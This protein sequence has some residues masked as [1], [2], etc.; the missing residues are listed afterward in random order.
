M[1][2]TTL[3]IWQITMPSYAQGSEPVVWKGRVYP[4]GTQI[5]PGIPANGVETSLITFPPPRGDDAQRY[6]HILHRASY[7]PTGG[8]I[9]RAGGSGYSFVPGAGFSFGHSRLSDY[10]GLLPAIEDFSGRLLGPSGLAQ[11]APEQPRKAPDPESGKDAKTDGVKCGNPVVVQTGNKIETEVDFGAAGEMGLVLAR[12]WNNSTGMV[13]M[14]GPKWVTVADQRLV[15]EGAAVQGEPG[16]VRIWRADGSN[17][18]FQRDTSTGRW[19]LPTGNKNSNFVERIPGT[20]T[21]RVVSSSGMVET[22]HQNGSLLSL[23]NPHSV[24]WAFDYADP[25]RIVDVRTPNPTLRSIIRTGGQQVI[26]FVWDTRFGKPVVRTVTAPDGGVYVYEY[27]PLTNRW[28]HLRTVTYPATPRSIGGAPVS[29]VVGYLADQELN[30]LGKEV[31]G[32]RYST[33][34]YDGLGRARTSEHAWGAERYTFNYAETASGTYTYVDNPLGKRTIYTYSLAGEEQRVDGLP[35]THC[36]TATNAVIERPAPNQERHIDADG[37]KVLLTFDEDRNVISMLQ[38][39]GTTSPFLTTYTWDQRPLRLRT[40]ITPAS[41]TVYTYHPGHGRLQSVSVRN[42]KPGIGDAVAKVTTYS[43]QFGHGNNFPSRIVVDGPLPGTGDAVWSDFNAAGLAVSS[44]SSV[45]T[46]SYSDHSG[47]GLARTVV[48]ANGLVQT[49][50]YDARSRMIATTVDGIGQWVAYDGHGQISE[51]QSQ[52]SPLTRFTYDSAGRF[53]RSHSVESYPNQI[54]RPDGSVYTAPLE[55]MVQVGRDAASNIVRTDVT[56]I[57]TWAVPCA[58]DFDAFNPYCVNGWQENRQSVPY[59]T[60]HT[61]FDEL[62]RIRAVRGNNGQNT[63]FVFNNGGQ[64]RQVFDSNGTEA[65]LTTFDEHLRPRTVRNA[66]G[67]SVV[68]DR[69]LFGLLS[70]VTDGKGNATTFK[71]DGLGQTWEQTSPDTGTT[72]SSFD[73]ATG[74]L[75]SILFADGRS[76]AYTYLADGR[77]SQIVAT[78]SGNALTR[79]LTYDI[80]THGRGR[81]CTVAETGGEAVSYAYNRNG[82]LA[83][84]TST[85]SGQPF[86]MGWSYH[87]ATGLPSRISYPNG[88]LVDLTWADGR[89]RDIDVRTSAAAAPVRVARQ[90]LYQPMGQVSSYSDPSGAMRVLYYDNDGR[91]NRILN[92]GGSRRLDYNN[93]NLITALTGDN[94]T[95]LGYDALHRVSSF[96]HDG[97]TVGLQFDAN[98]NRNQATYS[99]SPALPVTYVNSATSNRLT[100]VNWNGTSRMLSYDAV[101]NLRTDR[102]TASATD[103][104]YYDPLGRVVR[105]ARHAAGFNDC[106]SPS[107]AVTMNAVYAVNGLNQRTTKTVG[108]DVTRFVYGPSGELLYERRG[109]GG[110]FNEKAYIWFNGAVIAV[111]TNGSVHSVDS[112]HLGRPERVYSAQGALVWHAAN[113]P[114]SRNLKLDS[115]QGMN[116]G[117]P[118]QYFDGESGLWYNWH[119]YYEPALGRYTQ[120]DPIGLAGG[121]NTYSYAGGNPIQVIDPNGLSAVLL[122]GGCVASGAA[123]FVSADGFVAA[124]QD[125]QKAQDKRKACEAKDSRL[126]DAD[127]QRRDF[128]GKVA[129]FFGS[130]GSQIGAAI[131]KPMLIGVGAVAI[132]PA[133]GACAAA[134]FALGIWKG[135]GSTTRAIEAWIGIAAEKIGN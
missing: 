9:L 95:S 7:L 86:T 12:T 39:E 26:Q 112:D 29:T 38:G 93:L 24:G 60:M 87:V 59:V 31:D 37:Y 72:Q 81:L 134:G 15:M 25:A 48:D 114:F 97:L 85:A 127:P 63:R 36:P 69:D 109:V 45:G 94:G 119:R 122:A 117:F 54:W 96:T 108:S 133:K 11:G 47:S 111:V 100:H 51:A 106:A 1:L 102:R 83:T 57:E 22:Y 14:F 19:Q 18:V 101:G 67:Q 8:S 103:C 76:E 33:F 65:S 131:I 135:D 128:A 61:D 88:V 107:G 13:G 3:T 10:L 104:H 78:R 115:I 84:Q 113:A 130:F 21:L 126:G 27:A 121:M 110:G 23:F 132:D 5:G 62:N 90:I 79:T 28:G 56:R 17:L 129:D 58:D 6:E 41:E 124:A 123:G 92:R 71:T 2:A 91:L 64:T 105:I 118:G 73:P 98:G 46:T 68:F 43:Y 4:P 99:T 80:C 49:F 40:V 52:G 35:A 30:Y 34:T 116:V 42:L 89:L 125:F 55:N 75:S 74:R 44:S 20:Q 82:T 32:V 53:L 50:V 77:L 120:S 70:S 66:L 16:T